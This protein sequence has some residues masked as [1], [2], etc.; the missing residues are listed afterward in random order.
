MGGR[1]DVCVCVCAR[2]ANE[3][4]KVKSETPLCQCKV[5]FPSSI[6]SNYVNGLDV[7]EQVCATH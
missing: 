5:G 4:V 7:C 1:V 2:V 6:Q 3:A